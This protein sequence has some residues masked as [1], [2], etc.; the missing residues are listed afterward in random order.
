LAQQCIAEW[1]WDDESF[2]QFFDMCFHPQIISYYLEHHECVVRY[3][4]EFDNA[5]EDDEEVETDDKLVMRWFKEVLC[6]RTIREK[7]NFDRDYLMLIGRWWGVTLDE[8]DLE[9][10]R[11][12]LDVQ[13]KDY[14]EGLSNLANRIAQEKSCGLR[15]WTETTI[16]ETLSEYVCEK[17][18]Y[19]RIILGLIISQ[20][21][22]SRH[23]E[24]GYESEPLKQIKAIA[25]DDEVPFG[26]V[27][28]DRNQ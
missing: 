28:L 14:K 10:L 26:Y 19:L 4:C 15:G 9:L 16:K 12:T 17:T 13:F 11:E 21:I 6:T 2:Q 20:Q 1:E 18:D 7:V 25:I 27:P 22:R 23:E 8:K 24:E 5:S 3:E